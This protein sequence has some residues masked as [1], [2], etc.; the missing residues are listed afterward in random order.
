MKGIALSVNYP[1]HISWATLSRLPATTIQ[2]ILLALSSLAFI[3]LNISHC[4]EYCMRT[5]FISASVRLLC[6]F[7]LGSKVSIPSQ[8]STTPV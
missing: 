5:A 7:H 3:P 8:L 6:Y 2:S 4:H 1:R